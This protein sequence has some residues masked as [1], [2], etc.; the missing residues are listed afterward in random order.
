M[1][2]RK[3]DAH[4]DFDMKKCLEE[5]KENP[6]FYIQYTQELILTSF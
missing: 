3:N 6:I 4:L 2:V 1:L 5:S